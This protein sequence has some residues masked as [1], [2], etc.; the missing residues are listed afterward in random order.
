M[1]LPRGGWVRQDRANVRNRSIPGVLEENLTQEPPDLVWT[2]W[3]GRRGT[4]RKHRE[5][6]C[7]KRLS[8]VGSV[9]TGRVW[10]TKTTPKP[11]TKPTNTWRRYQTSADAQELREAP[12]GAWTQTAA[13]GLPEGV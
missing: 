2:D 7:K 6:N 5:S 12:C 10:K 9:S 4:L 1:Q 8:P 13:E 3:K 11:K